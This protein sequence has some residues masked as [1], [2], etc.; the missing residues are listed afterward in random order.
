MSD[1]RTTKTKVNAFAAN[2][3]VQKIKTLMGQ[4]SKFNANRVNDY[5]GFKVYVKEFN[6]SSARCFASTSPDNIANL[7]LLFSRGKG[8]VEPAYDFKDALN[9][10]DRNDLAKMIPVFSL[11]NKLINGLSDLSL[12]I[13]G[14]DSTVEYNQILRKNQADIIADKVAWLGSGD[15]DVY[16]F[17]AASTSYSL[18]SKSLLNTLSDKIGKI[19]YF[20]MPNNEIPDW[21][22]SFSISKVHSINGGFPYPG[23][24]N[25]KNPNGHILYGIVIVSADTINNI[26]TNQKTHHS[27]LYP[28][29]LLTVGCSDGK[30]DTVVKMM[31]YLKKELQLSG[32]QKSKAIGE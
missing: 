9:N 4:L 14:A 23:A 8:I 10:G 20:I 32:T 31:K 1:I 16:K 5:E 13:Y 17:I 15:T 6:N 26:D 24:K 21:V 28:L 29:S 12:N 3:S 22:I 30:A 19:D 11:T 7:K 27:G 25:I 18:Y 2:L